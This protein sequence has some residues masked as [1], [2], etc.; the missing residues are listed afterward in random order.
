MAFTSGIFASFFTPFFLAYWLLCPRR[1]GFQNGMLLI[2][3]YAIYVWADGRMALLLAAASFVA[4]AIGKRID[5]C[6]S[7]EARQRWAFV[8]L[9][10]HVGVLLFFKYC[11]YFATE[12]AA[13]AALLGWDAGPAPFR[14]V[15]PLGLSFYTFR[16]LGY[17]F[18]VQ[19]RKIAACSD[20]PAFLVFVS[21][22]P[23][24]VA[25]PIDRAKPL[26]GQLAATRVFDADRAIAALRHFIW[27]LFKKLVIADGLD[28][29]T[30]PVFAAPANYDGI[31]AIVVTVYYAIQLYADFSGYSDM[32]I[33]VSRLLGIDVARNFDHPFFARNIADFWRRWH[34]SLT[35]WLTDYLFTPISI[36]LRDYGRV[37]LA[38]A[39]VITFL[40]IGAWH[41][42][43]WTFV[44]FGAIHG[45]AYL[46]LIAAGTMGKKL[47]P[48]TGRR[49][50]S[51]RDALGIGTT[52]AFVA[53]TFV[54]FRLPSLAAVADFY[55]RWAD[56]DPAALARL[57]LPN[58][59][60][61][62]EGAPAVVSL[63]AVDW[64]SRGMETPLSAGRH[65]FWKTA[66]VVVLILVAGSFVSEQSF[67]YEVF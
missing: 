1:P 30:A 42:A 22:F 43:R 39:I 64:L 49:L 50:P 19:R 7:P 67:I 14:F 10:I 52:F 3:S 38:V 40:V 60:F 61:L 2:A 25:G 53:M 31:A 45:L 8:G 54:I 20:L 48:M 16:I 34:M 51:F 66:L 13:A 4:F 37:G 59:R 57:K 21:F 46:P 65:L 27:G 58:S 47:P 29:F 44:L 23:C 55:S 32:A 17:L 41:G 28:L 11:G 35:S 24:I 26:L 62:L 33:G 63:V 56:V 15:M 9:F 36:Q 6:L 5:A 18:D 12:I